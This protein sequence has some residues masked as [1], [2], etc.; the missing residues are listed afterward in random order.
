VEQLDSSHGS[1]VLAWT[2]PRGR[3]YLTTPGTADHVLDRLDEW[4]TTAAHLS[5]QPAPEGA[6]SSTDETDTSAP[7]PA[8]PAI[9]STDD[10]PF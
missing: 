7:N 8:E 4:A 9:T 5:R 6:T 1:G 10:P 2:S 3:T